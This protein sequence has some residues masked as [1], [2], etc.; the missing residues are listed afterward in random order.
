M[1]SFTSEFLLQERHSRRRT[2]D[3]A[4]GAE[5]KGKRPRFL[6]LARAL[7]E[8]R[9]D[10]GRSEETQ[11]RTSRFQRLEKA[12][13]MRQIDADAGLHPAGIDQGAD[14]GAK[15]R[16]GWLRL[17]VACSMG[18]VAGAAVAVAGGTLM[19]QW[20][21]T[22]P[23]ES[24][25]ASAPQVPLSGPSAIEEILLPPLGTRLDLR[26]RVV[27]DIGS[28]TPHGANENSSSGA[29]D[30]P[31]RL[32][33]GDYPSEGLDVIGAIA[34]HIGLLVRESD[35]VH[36]LRSV[37]PAA[38][39][40][41]EIEPPPPNLTA[42]MEDGESSAYDDTSYLSAYDHGYALQGQGRYL[43][44]LASYQVAIELKPA[45]PHALYNMGAVL[46]KVGRLEEAASAFEKAATL[47]QSNPFVY[48]DWGWTLEQ[49]GAVDMA[50]E[51]YKLAVATDAK[52]TAAVHA[53]KRLGVLQR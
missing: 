12:L 1:S 31:A 10:E 35:D 43:E 47:D 40:V 42:A 23:V 34:Q 52:S 15:P 2:D 8:A 38:A 27:G 22:S 30:R 32:S 7:E 9:L 18:V 25:E 5:A 41:A 49:A 51:K 46:S 3:A 36:E 24:R 13:A 20:A 26:P 14:E 53:H 21:A 6:R 17:P 37:S 45:T 33:G 44:A 28:Q 48:Y 50:I 19:A 11:H 29:D 16:P 39:Q 4:L